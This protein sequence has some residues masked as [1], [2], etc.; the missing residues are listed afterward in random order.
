[1]S[2]TVAILSLVILA[3]S[4]V[5]LWLLAREWNRRDRQ[6]AELTKRVRQLE[7][8]GKLRLPHQAA[9][10]L[11]NAMAVLDVE[12]GKEQLKLDYLE[13]IKGHIANAMSVGTKR[14]KG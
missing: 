2:H 9:D 10:E 11:L 8:A 1:M 13:N 14:Q 7:E 3:L 6:I 12:I 5:C 4:L